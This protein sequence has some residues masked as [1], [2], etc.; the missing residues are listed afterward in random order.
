MS[1]PIQAVTIP[2]EM[3][4]SG[5]PNAVAEFQQALHDTSL[6]T[7]TPLELADQRAPLGVLLRHLDREMRSVHND[8]KNARYITEQMSIEQAHIWG[9]ETMVR[10]THARLQFD[11]LAASISGFRNGLQQ[12]LKG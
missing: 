6:R 8:A 2:E 11:T 10:H 4:L 12:L 7:V 1:I 9:M 5:A 3:N